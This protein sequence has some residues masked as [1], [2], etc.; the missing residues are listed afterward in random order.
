MS[1]LRLRNQVAVAAGS[2]RG[3]GQGIA[4]MLR[5][6]GASVRCTGHSMRGRPATPGRPETI[7]ARAVLLT[8]E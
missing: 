6:A 8:A 1:E 3:A 2:T 7:E 4:R 5:A